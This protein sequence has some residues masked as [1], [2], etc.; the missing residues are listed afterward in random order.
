M[1]E[2]PRILFVGADEHLQRIAATLDGRWSCIFV[3]TVREAVASVESSAV[4]VVIDATATP[5]EAVLRQFLAE[6]ANEVIHIPVVGTTP[7]ETRTRPW[8]LRPVEEASLREAIRRGLE[9]HAGAPPTAGADAGTRDAGT[10]E[11][12]RLLPSLPHLYSRITSELETEGLTAEEVGRILGEDDLIARHLLSVAGHP[13]LGPAA[14]FADTASAT[15]YLGVSRAL[16]LVLA[17]E[18][19]R[20][21][22]DLAD[23]LARAWLEHSLEVAIFAATICL[24]EGLDRSTIDTAFTG[25]LLHD[26]GKLVLASNLPAAYR[27]AV[28]LARAE[29]MPQ[30]R[31][32][33][34]TI[35]STHSEIG[36]YVAGI[37]GLPTEI[38][39]V[40]L[41]HH[42]PLVA[43]TSGISALTAVHVG[44]AIS[45]GFAADTT[46][47]GSA[48]LDLDRR[49]LESVGVSHQLDWWLR[50]CSR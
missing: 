24:E 50:Q 17:V 14:R 41:D 32:E 40:I 35:G 28:T 6:Q 26:L 23:D 3:D 12:I 45:H 21:Y 7:E 42:T 8:L 20:Q 34:R 31:A 5:T 2:G 15:A 22:V 18:S 11:Q 27:R 13:G 1:G 33:I 19:Y 10:R 38:V 44:N 36:A 49:Y 16:A 48:H 43:Q 47:D 46:T 30:W 25:G 9:L 29:S 4:Q 37:W 39:S